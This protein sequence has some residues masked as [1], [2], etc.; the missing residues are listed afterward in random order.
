MVEPDRDIAGDLDVLPLVVANGHLVGVVEQNVGGLKG[1]VCEQASRDEFGLSLGRLVLELC[2]AAQFAERHRALHDPTEL[3]VGGDMALHENRRHIGVQTDGKKHRRKLQSIHADDARFF[4]DGQRMQVDDAVKNVGFVL[5]FDPV[6]QGTQIVAEMNLAGGLNARQNASHATTLLADLGRDGEVISLEMKY[7]VS[8]PTFAGPFELLL[9][10][11]LKEEVDIHEISLS[12]IVGAYLEEVSKMQNMDLDVATE[13]LL[14]A[15]TLIELKTRR[16]LPG[17]NDGDLDDEL[18][19][20]EERDLL[21]ARLL[22]CKT[23]KDVATV[24][25]DLVGRADLS[26]PR[27]AGPDE[28]FASLMPDLLEGVSPLRVQRAFL[29]ATAPKAPKVIGLEHVAPIR[30]SVADAIVTVVDQMRSAGR[31]T[32]REL[33]VGI[34]DRIEIVVRFLAILELFKQGRV[35]LDQVERFGDIEVVWLGVEDESIAIDN[36]EG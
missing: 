25:N 10:L 8:T 4:G 17:K 11:I 13:F 27:V 23:F 24:F 6:S 30:A 2:H 31:S 12:N 26:F 36:Y 15:A 3:A 32:F 5:S 1:G 7:A 19:L 20:W 34:G 35:D 14:I 29:R 16:L 22:D 18:A 33:V 28:R 9:H 21:L